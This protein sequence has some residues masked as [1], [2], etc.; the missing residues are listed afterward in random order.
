MQIG[1][2]MR[3]SQHKAPGCGRTVRWSEL[4]ELARLAEDIGV[5][6][7]FV[8]DHLVFR[9]APGLTIPNGRASGVWEGW[10]LL[11][12]LSQ[13]TQRV[14]LGPF[15]ACTT[16]RNPAL[17]AEMADTLDEVS[18]G[19]LILGLGAGWHE[20]EHA[21]FGYSFEPRVSR[22]EEA[23]QII[24]PLLHE[25]HVDFE[26][27]FYQARECEL[28]P[29][30]PRAGGPPIWIGARRPRMMALA[31]RYADAYNTDMLQDPADLDGVRAGFKILDDACRS[32]DRDPSTML[33]TSGAFVA[34]EGAAN[35]PAGLPSG[36]VSGSTGEVVDWFRR[37]RATG[38]EH[39]TIWL[40]PWN[41]RG[42]EQLAPIVEA[43]H[44]L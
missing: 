31:A 1:L 20:P 44:R 25:G 15:V 26:G 42:L 24:V 19:R 30:G 5:D 10:T 37:L 3:S 40:S 36:Y 39:A 22:F 34:L 43:V 21:A 12:A 2:M 9:P 27:R 35:D 11:T 29:R 38:V 32:V 8:A 16:F 23:L 41:A 18:N 17:L 28:L 7:L 14:R 4:R 33:R 6:T 13:V